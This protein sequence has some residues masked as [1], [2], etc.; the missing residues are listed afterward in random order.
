MLARIVTASVTH[1][2]VACGAFF[3]VLAM[4]GW[5]LHELPIDAIPDVTTVQVSVLT[6]VPGL[7]PEEVEQR[8]T[9]PIEAALN[10]V[11]RLDELRSISRAGLSAVTVVFKEGTDVWFA[12]QLVSERLR[13]AAAELPSSAGSPQLAP[14][15][16]GLGEI[17]QFV[18]RSNT[19]SALQLRTLLDWEIVPRLRSVPGIIEV[20]TMGGD[21]KQYQVV[22]DAARL[23]AHGLTVSELRDAI[24]HASTSVGGGYLE[25]RGEALML[26]GVGTLRSEDELRK[27]VVKSSTDGT[28]VLVQQVAEVK[29][30]AALRWGV[31]T[32]DGEGEAVSGV[33]M[34]LLG[35][36]SRDVIRAVKIKAD[37]IRAVLP[38]GVTL[39]VV[40]DRSD[41]IGRTLGTVVHNL[42]ESLLVVTV[43][44]ALL[45]GTIRGA[46]VV[47][48][49]IPA[50][51]SIALVGM[52]LFSVTGDI[53]S[54]GAID[55]G[56]LVDGPI[57]LLE[58]VMAATAGVRLS[59]GIR[60]IRYAEV[61]S[62]LGK[63]VA[64]SVAIIMLVY[65]P[66]LSLEGVEGKMFRPM[67]VTMACALFGALVY[68]LLL[69]PGLCAIFVPQPKEKAHHLWDRIGN[70]YERI[71]PLAMLRRWWLIGASLA[72][73]VTAL[74]LQGRNGADFVPRIEEGDLV[75]TIRRAP[76][77]SLTEAKRL[78]LA[79]E[80]V[81][82]RFPE[83]VTSLGMTGRAELAYDP[84]GNDNT[85]MLVHLRDKSLWTTAHDLDGL[86][87]A[88]KRAIEREVPGTFVSVSQPIEDRTN[89]IISGSR[90][91]AQLQL[92]GP[93][94]GELKR[95]SELLAREVRQV[96]G[97]GDVRVERLLGLPSLTVT[98]DRERLAQ[99]GV[100]LGDALQALVAA[101]MGLDAGVIFEGQ[102]RFGVRVISPPRDATPEAIGDFFVP[103][104]GG[105][106][107]P[108]A[109]VAHIEETE[110]PAQ[111]R[112][113][114]LMRTVRVEV[115]LRGRDLV[116]W[117]SE[118]QARVAT[119][120]PLPHGY[121][122]TWGGQFENF[123]RAKKR[124]GTVVPLAMAIIFTMLMAMFRR[125]GEALAVFA[126]VP[127]A[128][129]GG[130]AGL[131]IRG[132][133]FSIPA[134]VG[135]VALAGVCVLTGVVLT[136][137]ARRQVAHL[138]RDQAI[139]AAARHSLRSVITT[140][141]VA[142]FGFVPMAV[143][144]G[145][146]AEVQRPLATVVVFG[147]AGATAMTLFVLP[148]V[149]QWALRPTQDVLR[150]R[151]IA[152]TKPEPHATI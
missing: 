116:S 7:S 96:N 16:S 33:A 92:F 30:G 65:L 122:L 76:S 74:I 138:P 10:G 17:Y 50:A 141:V 113:E 9:F 11:P 135:F 78:D 40:Y 77:I 12:R 63:P 59:K 41:F 91:D 119:A 105:R 32:R 125:S 112:R 149:L 73:L 120:V 94:L 144:E 4:G 102:R 53:M 28:P 38:P 139:V 84:V 1:R 118:A 114:N 13:E 27:V 106:L 69:F 136:D 142:A 145:A 110:G 152:L 123:A 20:N 75:V 62:A 39:D 14:V 21:L 132:M 29:I 150:V 72:V 128:L 48:A 58:G 18:V 127:L 146:G 2:W 87:D 124:L 117:V 88:V 148:G 31:I 104:S 126:M 3:V 71:L 90:A 86:S 70:A 52:R 47:V 49:G 99:Y 51:M 107:V 6:D 25:R 15:S 19:Q 56:F 26:R 111:I 37:E 42:V 24:E 57:V 83:V 61:A 22:V 80:K 67:A 60:N 55:F 134:A 108:L 68:S 66:L 43:L 34:M 23:H 100:Q 85:D 109:E 147:I 36:N 115:N 79:A 54:L 93:D 103:A 45:L 82:A 44:L 133:P 35:A 95:L 89:E 137:E 143:A 101:R 64:Y 46:L 8:V 140:A 81:L 5:S 130:L 97:T 151:A 131:L 98:P 129:I 121:T